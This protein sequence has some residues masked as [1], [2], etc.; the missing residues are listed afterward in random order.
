M[1]AIALI[2]RKYITIYQLQKKKN[3]IHVHYSEIISKTNYIS[4]IEACQNSNSLK[5]I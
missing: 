2:I 3:T 5:T 1:Y 4:N